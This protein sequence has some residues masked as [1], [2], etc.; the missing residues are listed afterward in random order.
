MVIYN[1]IIYN[2]V[3]THMIHSFFFINYS[4]FNRKYN[5]LWTCLFIFNTTGLTLRIKHVLKVSLV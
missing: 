3:F 4:P 2:D 1:I 5:K